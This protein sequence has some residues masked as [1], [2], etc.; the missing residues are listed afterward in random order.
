[1]RTHP[2]GV[3]RMLGTALVLAC[4][5]AH[6]SAIAGEP[7]INQ[8]LLWAAETGSL[9]QV[10]TLLSKGANINAKNEKGQ[11]ALMVAAWRKRLEI[12]RCLIDNGADVNATNQYG[13]TALMDA[14]M[15]GHLEVVK[16][17]I[18]RGVDLHAKTQR[19]GTVLMQA[20]SHLK[21]LK[22]LIFRGPT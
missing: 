13:G 3:N 21:V 4:I 18:D 20:A 7:S 5:L 15:T 10:K 1:M 2:A 12:V 19:G 16:P 22:F 6:A 11:T 9:E 17:L 8:E 14:A